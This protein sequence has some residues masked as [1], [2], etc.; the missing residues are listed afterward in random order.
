[1]IRS[2]HLSY[3]EIIGYVAIGRLTV[4]YYFIHVIHF[5]YDNRV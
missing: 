3:T 2:T 1:M 5:I 4:V